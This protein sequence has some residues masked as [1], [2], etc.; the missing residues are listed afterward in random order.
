MALKYFLMKS[1]IF[2]M[3]VFRSFWIVSQAKVYQF[4]SLAREFADLDYL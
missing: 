1:V 3:L 2:K 4:K